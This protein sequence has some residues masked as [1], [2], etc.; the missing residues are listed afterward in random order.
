MLFNT[1]GLLPAATYNSDKWYALLLPAISWD[2]VCY[3]TH[4]DFIMTVCHRY[5]HEMTDE[6]VKVIFS[7]HFDYDNITCYLNTRALEHA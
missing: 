2:D 7:A 1:Q 4:S 5:P 3:L 6:M